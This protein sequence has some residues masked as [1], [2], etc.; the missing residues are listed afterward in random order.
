M[1]ADSTR[2]ILEGFLPVAAVNVL[3]PLMAL[4]V[5]VNIL[6]VAT[7]MLT[8][9]ERRVV[10]RMQ[11]RVGPNRVG[12][13]G[14]LQ[15]F[16]DLIKLV[17]KEDMVP[18][19][20]DRVAFIVAPI[21]GFVP[22][23]MIFAVVPFHKGWVFA[24][25]DAG[26]VYVIAIT[27]IGAFAI[28]AAGWASNNKYSLLG[29]VRGVAQIVSYEVPMILAVTSVVLLAGSLNLQKIVE[30]QGI[31]FILV[32]PLA[33]LIMLVAVTAELNRTPFDLM[34]AE[35]EIVAGFHTEYSGTKFALI[36]ATEYVAALGWS[37]VMVTL[38]LGGWK[39]DIG[40]LLWFSA[41]TFGFVLIFFWFRG[42][43]P[44]VRIDQI[45][46]LAWKVLFPLATLNVLVTAGEVL[47]AQA[48]LD[49]DVADGLP[50]IALAAMAIVNLSLTAIVLLVL[51]GFMGLRPES[52]QA[53]RLVTATAATR[54]R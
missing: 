16:A 26:I 49:F 13:F 21:V 46:G 52:Q 12:P 51:P 14:T 40:G 37:A 42:T 50:T 24:D 5:F 22:A 33:F 20:A 9:V 54:G 47:V 28:F 18:A 17:T 19:A 32:Q 11:N 41:K 34:E 30:A 4:F 2:R 45:L 10:A 39:P 1:I 35:S 25:L 43:W 7:T 15:G 31:P 38:F 23:M 48:L 6:L 27:S 36:Y 53:T 3:M 8:Y 29:A 44:R